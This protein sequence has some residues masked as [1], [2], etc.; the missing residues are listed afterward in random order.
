[1][2]SRADL[3][4]DLD[5]H[6]DPKADRRTRGRQRRRNEVYAVAVKLFIEQGF[7]NTTMDE[8]AERADVARATVFNYYPRKTAF[9]DEW[10]TRRRARASAATSDL[11]G[12][13]LDHLLRRYMVEMARLSEETRAETRA[14][15]SATLQQT[16]FLAHPQL[17]DELATL[18]RSA[19][20]NAVARA[21]AHAG[22][23]GLILATAYFAVLDQWIA[24][25]PSP[26]DLE[27]ELLLV[28]DVVLYG[29]NGDA[30]GPATTRPR[31]LPPKP[32]TSAS[33]G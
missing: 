24:S 10:T 3:A 23:V 9:L 2:K 20:V 8:I 21:H 12:E 26:F 32:Q 17:A 31:E 11:E 16:N 5:S 30:T 29:V 7:D 14:L 18:I 28:V 6:I 25:E 13:P 33:S 27:S 19:R 1:M 4:V 22:R 15:L